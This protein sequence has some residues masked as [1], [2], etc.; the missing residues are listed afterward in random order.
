MVEV[1][2]PGHSY[3]LKS[4]GEAPAQ[5]LVFIK[6]QPKEGSPDELELVHDGTTTEEVLLVLVDRLKTLLSRVPDAFTES[7]LMHVGTALHLL[8]SRT[9]N[10]T[11]RGV[12]G[13]MQA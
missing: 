9:R 12:E 7:A 8:E 2:D 11:E 5:S 10:R 1:L 6:K 13:T 4:V 3:E